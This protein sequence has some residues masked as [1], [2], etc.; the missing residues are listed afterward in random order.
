MDEGIKK[1]HGNFY[2]T[3]SNEQRCKMQI[4]GKREMTIEETLKE[5]KST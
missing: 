1:L 4:R 2:E 5:H 3:I